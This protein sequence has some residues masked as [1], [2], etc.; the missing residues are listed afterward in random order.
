LKVETDIITSITASLIRRCKNKN[1]CLNNIIFIS[2]LDI[3]SLISP[4]DIVGIKEMT[5]ILKII[6]QCDVKH[7]MT[8]GPVPGTFTRL[9]SCI[10]PA[11]I[12]EPP[13]ISGGQ[14]HKYDGQ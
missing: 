8:S 13:K 10:V 9:R 7:I 3:F 5:R 12:T 11:E 1:A 6:G 2:N 4:S 14:N